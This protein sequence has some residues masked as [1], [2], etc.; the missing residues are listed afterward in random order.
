MQL[1]YTYCPITDRNTVLKDWDSSVNQNMSLCMETGYHTFDSWKEGSEEV[2]NLLSY[3]PEYI[4]R[5]KIIDKHSQVWTKIVIQ[6]PNVVIYP[7]KDYE[8]NHCWF[9]NSFR[10]LNE[11]EEL[12]PS[13]PKYEIDGKIKVLDDSTSTVFGKDEFEAAFIEFHKLC[14]N[15]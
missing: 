15:G 9:V 2:A 11:N 12:N 3:S 5:T 13:W 14:S 7:D 1:T 10:F 4:D 8:G 6:T